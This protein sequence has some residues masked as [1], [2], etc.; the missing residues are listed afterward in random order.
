MT[1]AVETARPLIEARRHELTLELPPEPLP[2]E[3]DAVR[4][5]QV[6][7]NL[8]NNA[9]KYTE[10]GGKI[11]LTAE[12]ASGGRQPP[13]EIV[14][15]VRD[16]GVGIA[17]ELLPR[18]FDLF[19]QADHPPNL[20]QGGLGIGLTLV[21][22]LVEMHGGRVE[23]HSDGPGKGS[24]F[25]VRLPAAPGAASS[26]PATD[27]TTERRAIGR[28]VLVLDDNADS[29]E[30]LAELLRLWGHEVRT[31]HSGS[32]ALDAARDFKPDAALLDLG[33]PDMNGYEAARL[34]RERAGLNG[35]AFIALT[36]YGQEADRRRSEEAGFQAHLVKPVD[37]K[38][39]R[40]LLAGLRKT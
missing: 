2:L 23:A 35:T 31:A 10:P 26:G 12:S 3:G 34:L 15:R 11:W 40:E 38:A 16:S 9:A 25:V 5:A 7:A 14:L 24:E 29:A 17:P 4:L 37:P 36:G 22:R 27:L 28:R 32:E 39:L 1:R 6:V 13:D 33:M 20:A 21:K 19:V 18:I 30:S 8:L